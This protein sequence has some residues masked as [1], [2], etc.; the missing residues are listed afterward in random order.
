M[1]KNVDKSNLKQIIL[2]FPE[3]FAQGI[4]IAKN[5]K[6]KGNFDRVIV[7]GMGGSAIAGDVLAKWLEKELTILVNRTYQLP[8]GINKKS[9]IFISSYSG[10]TEE[11]IAEYQEARKKKLTIVCFCS[12]GELERLCQKERIPLVNIPKGFPSRYALGL[13]F[14]AMATVLSNSGLIKDRSK[15]IIALGKYLKKLNN[16]KPGGKGPWAILVGKS[17]AKKLIGKIPLIYASDKYKALA[18]NWKIKFNENSKSPAFANYFPEL[19]HNELEGMVDE[20]KSP[21]PDKPIFHCLILRDF[22]DHPRIQKGMELTA[23]ILNQTGLPTEI[24]NLSGQTFLE[25][26]FSG[27]LLADWTSFWLA[28]EYGV[29]PME[30]KA[31]EEFKKQLT[32]NR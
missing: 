15:E 16:R 20:R 10:N 21:F 14:S 27:I 22:D 32:D 26:I 8:F 11:V 6:V 4:E 9:L 24:I 25:K 7:C 30:T 1:V 31:I 29:D 5:I 17:L 18:Y 2:D 19:N 12:G 13:E 28:L 23:K 3:Q